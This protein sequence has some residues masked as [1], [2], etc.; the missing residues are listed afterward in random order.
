[1]L[2]EQ[3]ALEAA[4]NNAPPMSTG[5]DGGRRQHAMHAEDLGEICTKMKQLAASYA[6]NRPGSVAL[7]CLCVGFVLGWKLKPW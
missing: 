4:R 3:V 5:P 2:N 7:A 1:M 6:I